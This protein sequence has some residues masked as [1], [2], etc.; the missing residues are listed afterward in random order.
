MTPELEYKL[1][2]FKE[3]GLREMFLQ[4]CSKAFNSDLLS[5]ITSDY[6]KYLDVW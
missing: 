3:S 6:F 5:V 4:V 1:L 2:D